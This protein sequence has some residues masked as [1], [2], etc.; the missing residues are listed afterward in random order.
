VLQDLWAQIDTDLV[1][2]IVKHLEGERD[3]AASLVDFG[4]TNQRALQRRLDGLTKSLEHPDIS[5]AARKV[6]LGQLDQVAQEL[7]GVRQHVPTNLHRD[8]ELHDYRQMAKQP[9]MFAMVPLTWDDESLTWRRSWVRRFIERVDVT[10]TGCSSYE[11]VIHYLSGDVSQLALNLKKDVP[12]RELDLVRK[13]WVHPKRPKKG[14]AKWIAG[15]LEA[16]RF[17]RS[18][19]AIYRLVQLVKSVP[20]ASQ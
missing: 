10:K 6:L 20:P 11:V 8:Q 3:S 7:D 18:P 15:R 4:E 5:E 13:L 16:H 14:W 12:P 17:Q 9:D 1:G 19:R 2:R